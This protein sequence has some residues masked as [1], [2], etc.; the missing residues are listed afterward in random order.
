[1]DFFL[2][3]C[4]SS[5]YCLYLISPTSCPSIA[6][7]KLFSFVPKGW[8]LISRKLVKMR[9]FCTW[10][11]QV[12]FGFDL[13]LCLLN[14]LHISRGSLR[15]LWG[16]F[17]RQSYFKSWHCLQASLEPKELRSSRARVFRAPLSPHLFKFYV[18]SEWAH[19]IVLNYLFSCDYKHHLSYFVNLF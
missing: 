16:L 15:F 2:P 11:T 1:M 17:Q 10:S 8:L 6:F 7:N 13:Q 5:P 18:I 19:F 4:F 9:S 3:Q 14:L 12:M